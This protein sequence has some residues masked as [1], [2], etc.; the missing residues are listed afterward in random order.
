[1][2]LIAEGPDGVYLIDQHAAH[3]RVR[4]E[5]IKKALDSGTPDAQQLLEPEPVSLDPRQEELLSDQG[6]LIAGLGFVVEPF[7]PGTVLIRAIPRMLADHTSAAGDAFRGLLDEVA[8][9]GRPDAWRERMIATLACHSSVRAGMRLTDEEGRAL[10]RRL[11]LAEQPHTCPHG[12]P[13]MIHM[14]Q[15]DLERGFARR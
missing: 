14:S 12:R 11:E 3:E 6:E 1:M 4:Y 13:T 2:Y 7:G 8:S 15:P 5:E 9:G 10:V